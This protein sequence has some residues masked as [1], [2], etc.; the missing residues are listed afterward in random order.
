MKPSH[1]H[2]HGSERK[3]ADLDPAMLPV[4]ESLE[5]TME[6]TLPLWHSRIWPDLLS[7]RNVLIVAHGNSLRGLVKHIDGLTPEEI[8][9]VG[10]PNGIPLV[11][12]FDENGKPIRART[13]TASLTKQ[14]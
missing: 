4:T 8:Q 3:Y 6:R 9:V 1:R 13:G 14:S 7:G 5:D 12:K 2:W 11:Y 10:I